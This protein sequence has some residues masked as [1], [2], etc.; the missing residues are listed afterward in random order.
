MVAALALL[1]GASIAAAQSGTDARQALTRFPESQA[2]LYLNANRIVNVAMPRVMPAAEYQKMLAETK[3]GG[4]DVRGLDYA[5]LGV[6]FAPGAP[7]G[8]MPEVAAM[9]RGDFNA[10]A[11]LMLARAAA[12][13]KAKVREETH[14]S[15]P[16]LILEMPKKTGGTGQGTG[17]GT[18]DGTGEAAGDSDQTAGP[19]TSG[20]PLPFP[21]LA[22]VA[23][24]ANTL[25]VGVP[26]YV[27]AAID[28]ESGGGGLKAEMVELASRDPF[29]LMSLT[30]DLP[31]NMPE[32]LQKLGVNA[33]D[34]VRRMIGW[35]KS[36]SLSAGMD[37][38][39]FTTKVAVLT[40]APEQASTLD[41]MLQ[42]ALTAGEAAL[43][44]EVAKKKN[45][46]QQRAALNALKSLTHT[47]Q[48]STLEIG[49]S[50][51]QA[52]VAE[53]IRKEMSKKPAVARSMRQ[54]RPTRGGARRSAR[55]R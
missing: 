31:E 1:S 38:R 37:D 25:V 32:Y 36:L 5:I 48:G 53:M 33:N 47:T 21:E 26:S 10:Y 11:L 23:L 6:R 7:A 28:A 22:A 46:S 4:V 42:F 41:G 35:L 39:N 45:A 30:A 14:N 51:P 9:V 20:S 3:K 34:E 40:S 50:V 27:R 16:L 43:S 18:G 19:Q 15:K 49:M 17:Q 2:V 54:A 8:A 24:D 44:S 13:D 52:T 12:G 55:R 29:A